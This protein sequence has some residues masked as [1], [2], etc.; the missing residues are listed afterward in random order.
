MR[1]DGFPSYLPKYISLHPD[2]LHLREPS[3]QRELEDSKSISYKRWNVTSLEGSF[4][5][6]IQAL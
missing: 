5:Y 4:C 1:I 3:R 6:D 2:I